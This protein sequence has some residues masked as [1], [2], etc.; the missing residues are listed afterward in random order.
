M[1]YTGENNTNEDSGGGSYY[2]TSSKL[3]TA[4]NDWKTISFSNGGDFA[5]IS[6]TGLNGSTS[7][8]NQDST[9]GVPKQADALIFSSNKLLQINL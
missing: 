5:T 1:G 4:A 8:I 2:H 3:N 7:D 9:P 6:P